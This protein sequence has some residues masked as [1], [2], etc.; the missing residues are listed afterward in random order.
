MANRFSKALV[1]LIAASWVLGGV[2]E[3]VELSDIPEDKRTPLNL[4]FTA[5]E[6]ST[7]LASHADETLVVDIRDPAEVFATGMAGSVDT[8][9]PFKRI[10][11]KKWDDKK[12][13][14]AFAD[15][16]KFLRDIK[17]KL[18]AKGLGKDD[19]IVL[20]CT[21][22]KRAAKATGTLAKAGY[23]KVYVVVDGYKGWQAADLPWSRKL[24]R[25]KVYGNPR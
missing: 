25:G 13:T 19:T 24:D 12:S 17:A 18:K 1:G 15:N 22:G 4:Y 9:L 7:H 10:N 11:L 5:V 3:A 16:P 6:L 2:A 21:L 8:N 14:Y 23:K 20:M